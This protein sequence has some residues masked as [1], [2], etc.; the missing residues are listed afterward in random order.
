MNL[1]EE[2]TA[3]NPLVSIIIVT[4]NRKNETI[5]CI[6]SV[7]RSSYSPFEIVVVDNASNDGTY[8]ELKKHY[9]GSIRLIKNDINVY[10]GGG[11]NIG[12][13]YARG[14]YLLFIDSDNSI[15]SKMIASL[16]DGIKRNKNLNVGIAGPFTYYKFDRKRLCWTNS[17]ISLLTSR[18][19]FS[20]IGQIDCG[21]YDKVDYVKVGHIPNVFM[22]KKDVFDRVGGI[23]NDY[24]MH[25]E[26]SDLAE[27]ISRLG[28]DI[29]LFPQAKTWHN[30]PPKSPM[31]HKS[32]FGQNGEM[33]YYVARNRIVFM[34]KNSQGTNLF[35][36]LFFFSNLFFLYNLAI[37][38]L[39]GRINLMKHVLK[40]YIDGLTLKLG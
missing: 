24:I 40:G 29:I 3:P 17:S 35:I 39:N 2:T 23:D 26:E 18:T 21:Q 38:L 16:I 5:E 4:Y 14:I 1:T 10:A 6:D 13:H 28:Y 15:D 36:F 33:V 37:L 25:Y 9:H 8:D 11:R 19:F 31:G 7:L 22:V 20:G 27:K 34:R 32:F 12:A 30:L